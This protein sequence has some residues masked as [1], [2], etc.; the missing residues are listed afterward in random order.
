MAS[1]GQIVRISFA[2]PSPGH[3]SQALVAWAFR[4][5]DLTRSARQRGAQIGLGALTDE[6]S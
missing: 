6:G 4:R 2:P 3:P 5:A 1:G